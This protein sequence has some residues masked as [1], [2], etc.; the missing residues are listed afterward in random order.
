MGGV[1]SL[2]D[3]E[4]F[5][6]EKLMGRDRRRKERRKAKGK[7]LKIIIKAKNIKS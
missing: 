6:F 4:R 5:H 1:I 2:V 7:K 3:K